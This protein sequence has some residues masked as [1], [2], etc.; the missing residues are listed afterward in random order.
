MDAW[1]RLRRL[2]A[3]NRDGQFTSFGLN[4]LVHFQGC[5][6]ASAT[7][8]A[9]HK[10]GQSPLFHSIPNQGLNTDGQFPSCGLQRPML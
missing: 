5:V 4:K 3:L 9:L 7:S 8:D 6:D 10:D 1:T 2:N